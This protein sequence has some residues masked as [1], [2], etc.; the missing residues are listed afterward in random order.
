M[1]G[2]AIIGKYPCLLEA[3]Y[4]FGDFEVHPTV[5]AVL[6][7]V[8]LVDELLWDLVDTNAGIFWAIEW[9]FEVEVGKIRC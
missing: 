2:E 6:F 3:V 9:R 7:K 1:L 5:V 8:L 4:T